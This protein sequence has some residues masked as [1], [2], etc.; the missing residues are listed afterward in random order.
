MTEETGRGYT[1]AGAGAYPLSEPETSAVFI[2]L[3]THPNVGDR[4]VA[5]HVRAD[6]PARA[7]DEQV[8]ESMFPEDLE[9]IKKFDQKGLEI[10]GYPWAG[11]TF[12][13]YAN[14][15]RRDPLTGRTPRPAPLFG[16]GP[17]FG[18]LYYGAVWYGN[19]IWNGGRLREADGQ[20]RPTDDVEAAA[21]ARRE[22]RRQERLPAVDDVEHPTLGDGRSRR[23]E[24]EVLVAEPAARDARDVG[25]QRSDVQ[26]LPGAAAAAGQHRLGHVEA[27]AP[28]GVSTST[29]TV[30]NE[31]GCRPR[32]RSRKR[33]KMVRP[34]TC[35]ITLA[36]GQALVAAA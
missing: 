25:A 4:A 29:M 17:E 1:Q 20:G 12:F 36:K 13:V 19:E 3:M 26:P 33:V 11:D 9:L 32:S 35:T 8:E 7:V 27:A 6:D 10:T 5:R 16:H 21:V 15:R 18:Y 22:S 14:A 2:F 30:T 23:L 31:G 34:D 28:T 24:P